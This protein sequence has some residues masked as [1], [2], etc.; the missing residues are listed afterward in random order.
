MD[1]CFFVRNRP[2]RDEVDVCIEK[3]LR[4]AKA[5]RRR[6][7][8][9]VSP[10]PERQKLQ[11]TLMVVSSLFATMAFQVGVNPPGGVW[12]EDTKEHQA[13]KAILAYNFRKSYSCFIYFNTVG[14]LLS[15]FIILMLLVIGLSTP[16]S[17]LGW[18]LPVTS[19]LTIMTTA[20]AYTYSII[21]VSPKHMIAVTII[22]LVS[23]ILWAFVMLF[24][25][26]AFV[27]LHEQ[28]RPKKARKRFPDF[29]ISE[30]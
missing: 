30:R 17:R 3:L 12:Q 14:F 24:L 29:Q 20:F 16:K 27:W 13:G 19:L 8:V 11:Q 18:I 1:I 5:K 7:M 25:A 26:V 6:Q 28:A 9:V 21:V 2:H 4:A 23:V 22:I 10:P 15:L